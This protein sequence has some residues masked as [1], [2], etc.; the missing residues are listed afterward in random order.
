MKTRVTI[1]LDDN[2]LK[3]LDELTRREG[4]N[5]RS[6]MIEKIIRDSVSRRTK[7]TALVLAG[8]VGSRLRP[9]T[10]ETPKPMITIRGKPI[11]E[12]VVNALKSAGIED[13]IISISYL[14]EKIKSH[15]G[16]GDSFGVKIKYV[17][18]KKALGTGGAIKN[19][20]SMIHDDVF[21]LNGD[22]LFDFDLS[23][24]YE[25][26]NK[27][28][29]FATIALTSQEKTSSFGVVNI[30]GD[31]IT[32]FVE[33]PKTEQSSHLINAGIYILSPKF[34]SMLPE[35]ESRVESMFEKLAPKGVINGFVYSGK[36]LPCDSIELYDKAI[37]NWP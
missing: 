17:E 24:M 37:K 32:S 9:L 28:R 14:G 26:H 30:D 1:T 13:I 6:F 16:N 22:N 35:G 12:Y 23:K 15:F 5:S 8:G 19:C 4:Y 33:K 10:Y 20:E 7:K 29:P 21:V 2:L 3:N 34:I 27:N 25:A 18:E 36:W 31:K 11:L